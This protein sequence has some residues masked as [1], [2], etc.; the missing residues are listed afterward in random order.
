MNASAFAALA[1]IPMIT[2]PLPSEERT[3]TLAVC[4]GAAITID[5]GD[6]EG[7]PGPDCHQKACHAGNCR[8]K[9]KRGNLI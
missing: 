4:N 3:L 1:L 2:G 8:E 6:D 5:L 9:S 7:Q